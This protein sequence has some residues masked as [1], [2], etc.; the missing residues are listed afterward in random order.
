[1][2][3]PVLIVCMGVSSCGKTS[4]A[5]AL[6][7]HFDLLY[8]EADAFHSDENKACMAAGNPLTDAMREP[9]VR[10][11][12]ERLGE[13]LA[14]GRSCVLACSA[15][16]KSHRRNFRETGF[17]TKFLF[18]D[19]SRELI[20]QWISKR[21]GHFMPPDLLDSQFRALETPIGEPDVIRI[22]LDRPWSETTAE[23]VKLTGS[24][25][26]PG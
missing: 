2:T 21:K 22:R 26:I 4:L 15:L 20:S 13:E 8:L 18:M 5:Q 11:I 23:A 24:I 9:W 7:A 19:G 16:R 1:M 6:A 12:C 14:A 3:R 10:S 25:L 17:D